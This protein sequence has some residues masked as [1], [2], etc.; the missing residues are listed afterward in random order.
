MSGRARPRAGQTAHAVLPAGPAGPSGARRS[1]VWLVAAFALPALLAA[2]PAAAFTPTRQEACCQSVLQGRPA[3]ETCGA[4]PPP[5]AAC[6]EALSGMSRA[7]AARQ[8][9]GTGA[10]RSPAADPFPGAQGSAPLPLIRWI[11][12]GVVLVVAGLALCRL[13]ARHIVRA[14]VALGAFA[15]TTLGATWGLWAAACAWLR[16]VD[17]MGLGI[18]ILALLPAVVA[19]G[20]TAR[21]AWRWRRVPPGGARDGADPGR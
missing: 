14:A 13:G 5:V 17:T 10:A 15:I 9:P 8:E 7:A 18:M 1:G 19:G 6:R 12:W 11:G 16:C 2:G 3:A 20:W 4:S 21:W